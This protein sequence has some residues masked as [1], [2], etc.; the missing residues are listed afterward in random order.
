MELVQKYSK[1]LNSGK[2]TTAHLKD[3]IKDADDLRGLTL[4]QGK[5]I[6]AIVDSAEYPHQDTGWV[7]KNLLDKAAKFIN[8]Q[9]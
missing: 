2:M 8:E 9:K 5:V 1:L 3:L 7:L 6:E 4:K